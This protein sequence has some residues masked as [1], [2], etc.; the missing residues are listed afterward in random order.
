MPAPL[1]IRT[2]QGKLLATLAGMKNERSSWDPHWM[3]L[4]TFILPRSGRFNAGDRNR[5]GKKHNNI[6]DNSGTR[7]LR[8]LG[9]GLMSGATNPSRPWF[10]LATPDRALMKLEPV[11]IWLNDVTQ[12]MLDVFSRSNTYQ[13]LHSIYE[14]LG[15]FG[16]GCSIITDNF[17]KIIHNNALTIGEFSFGCDHENTVNAL[18]REF[19]MTVMQMIERFGEANCSQTVRRMYGEGNYN[20]WVPVVHM[21]EPRINRDRSSP[22]AK[23]MP[24]KS[25]YLEPGRDDGDEKFLRNSGFKQFRALAPR[26]HVTSNNIYGDSCGMDALGD[27]KQ[28]QHEQ[29]RKAENIDAETKPALQVPTKLKGRALDRLPGGVSYYDATGPGQGVRRLFEGNINLEH[30]LMDI[31]DVR[32]RIRNAF[33]TDLFFAISQQDAG[34]MTAFE[35]SA[36]QQEQLLQLGPVLERLHNELLNPLIDITF[37]RMLEARGPNGESMLPD[38]PQEL[39]GVELKIEYTSILA[40]AQRAVNTNAID[41]YTFSLGTIAQFKPGVLDKFDEDKWAEIYADNLGVDPELIV[42]DNKVALIRQ[43]RQ[44]QQEAAQQAAMI[45]AGADTAQKLSKADTGGKNALTDIVKGSQQ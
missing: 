13:S 11:K 4:E 41:R 43:S 23:D 6:Y 39:Q 32:E 44:Q 27:V 22:D 35:A 21:I 16:T 8:I 1:D 33:Y 15:C 24:F 2:E 5:G 31:Q 7:A 14:E 17:D 34:K 37:T 18:A 28:L 40:Q 9:A 10:R 29:V 38:P 26:W 45:Q 36:R 19:E 3:E 12:I 30:L 20:A 42:A 25:V